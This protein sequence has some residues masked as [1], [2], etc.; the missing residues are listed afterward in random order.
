MSILSLGDMFNPALSD[1]RRLAAAHSFFN[2]SYTAPTAEFMGHLMASFNNDVS[3]LE[4][5]RAANECIFRCGSINFDWSLVVE[6]CSSMGDDESRSA[7]FSMFFPRYIGAEPLS[8]LLA[9]FSSDS[10]RYKIFRR[11]LS[12]FKIWTDEDIARIASLFSDE[13]NEKV[14]QTLSQRRDDSVL[15]SSIRSEYRAAPPPISVPPMPIAVVAPR[16]LAPPLPIA[17]VKISPFDMN[18]LTGVDSEAAEGSPSQCAACTENEKRV[19]M[20]PCGHVCLCISCAKMLPKPY[21]CPM[22]RGAIT[23]ALGVFY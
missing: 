14:L 5:L 3:R 18:S 15:L 23:S 1:T 6:V 16:I 7:V 8:H 20:V 19:A 4:A 13:L 12:Y 11:Y 21:V 22:C 10:K 2:N 17:A 9:T